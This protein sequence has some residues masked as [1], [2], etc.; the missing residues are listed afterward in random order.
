MAVGMTSLLDCPKF[1]W[2]FGCTSLLPRAPPS[3]S[4]ARF[5]IT[6]FVFMLVDVPEPV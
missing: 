3:S 4:V 5:E 2:S 1:T 6:S